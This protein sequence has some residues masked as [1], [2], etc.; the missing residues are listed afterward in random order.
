MCGR[1]LA[2]EILASHRYNRSKSTS[3][4]NQY[5]RDLRNGRWDFNG[6]PVIINGDDLLNG[7]HRLTA[8]DESNCTIPLVF[9]YGIEPLAIRT[10]DTGR[11]RTF[12]QM[13]DI[14]G[15]NAPSVL[16]PMVQLLAAYRA[17]GE[18]GGKALTTPELYEVLRSEPTTRDYAPKY[19]RR[20]PGN[21]S[22]GLLAC[23]HYLFAEKDPELAE[24]Y[25]TSIV[26]GESLTRED[27]AYVLREWLNHADRKDIKTK[28]VGRLLV[29]NWNKTRR[30]EKSP[31]T[32]RHPK[33]CPAI[34]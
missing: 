6:Q 7:F 28:T 22:T 30:G 8:I 33:R 10:M 31:K 3:K 34:E 19:S 17:N 12:S 18:F 32:V 11:P 1:D 23:C 4:I 14:D 21:F 2:R 13:L 16:G 24:Q 9:E 25:C 26:T 15:E 20:V 27:P 5:I 29:D